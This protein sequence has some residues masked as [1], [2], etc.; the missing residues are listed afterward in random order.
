MNNIL[1]STL[2]Y[3][4]YFAL[5]LFILLIFLGVIAY[6][7]PENIRKKHWILEF[8]HNIG[9]NFI[10]KANQP[11]NQ[12]NLSF[13]FSSSIPEVLKSFKPEA[14]SSEQEL[15]KQLAQYLKGKGFQVKRQVHIGERERV[16]LKVSDGLSDYFIEIKEINSKSAIDR[17]IG[18]IER[19]L[20]YLNPSQLIFLALITKNIDTSTLDLIRQKGVEVIEIQAFKNKNNKRKKEININIKV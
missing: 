19:Y 12:T 11:S 5:G 4:L 14:F 20:Q 18:Q 6:F 1:L 8:L 7:L 3:L 9:K 16:D 17:S 2:H 13:N 10:E 15:E